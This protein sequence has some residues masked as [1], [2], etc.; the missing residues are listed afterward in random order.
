MTT[1]RQLDKYSAIPYC[2]LSFDCAD[3]VILVQKELFGREVILPQQRLRGKLGQQQI[4]GEVLRAGRK[5]E[6]RD[7]HDGDLVLMKSMGVSYPG[8]VGV[9]FTLDGDPCVLHTTRKIGFS[10]VTPLRQLAQYGI[11]LEGIYEWNATH[12]VG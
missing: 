6:V 3:L 5:V 11:N 10:I 7:A 2:P 1:H 8:H 9:L 4:A 12:P